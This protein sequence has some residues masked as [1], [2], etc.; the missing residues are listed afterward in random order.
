MQKLDPRIA[1]LKSTKIE[2]VDKVI[3]RFVLREY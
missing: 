2:H 1:G 3:A